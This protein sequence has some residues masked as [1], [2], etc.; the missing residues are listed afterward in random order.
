VVERADV[1]AA[2]PDKTWHVVPVDD[3]RR[4]VEVGIGCWCGPRVEAQGRGR[5]LV[6]HHSEDGRELVERHGLQ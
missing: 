2:D 5:W 4:H 1:P 6:V 3:L